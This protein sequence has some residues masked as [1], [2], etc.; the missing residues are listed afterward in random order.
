MANAAGP[1]IVNEAATATNPTLIPNK[2]EVDTGYGW[3]AADTLTAITGGTERMRIDASGDVGIG[4]SAYTGGSADPAAAP[5]TGSSS[6]KILKVDGGLDVD[7][8]IQIVGHS[9]PYGM[10]LWTDVSTGDAYIDNRGDHANYDIH[11]RTRTT[12][13]P[14]DAMTIAGAGYVGIG[15]ATP[16]TY[17]GET[18]ALI[19]G[20]VADASSSLTLSCSTSGSSAI[21]FTD[22][23]STATQGNIVYDHGSNFMVFKT[24]TA[25][26]MRILSDGMLLIGKS[27]SNNNTKGVE[28]TGSTGFVYVGV[29]ENPVIS[30]NRFTSTGTIVQLR[31]GNA[32]KGTISTDG[33]N[34]AFNT[35]SDYR[36]K[37]NIV[38]LTGAVTRVKALQPRRFNWLTTPDKTYDGFIAHEASTVVPEAVTGAKDGTKTLSN[39]IVDADGNVI[40]E[41]ITEAQ[42]ALGKERT[43]VSGTEAEEAVLYIEGDELPEGKNTGDIKTPAIEADNPEYADPAYAADT[44]WHETLTVPEYQGIDQAKLV[45]LLT[46]AIQELIT[47]V[48]TLEAA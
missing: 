17:V 6:A 31:Y 12:G 33:S 30:L 22:V 2:A 47:R 19:I 18:S 32:V 36:L 8:A 39:V 20:K 45:P 23:A 10:D 21:N 41:N 43:L 40:A 9:N 15:N 1:T 37:E 16:S 48:E 35:S 26:R 27:A 42:W 44:V 28:I 5:P 24:N 38:D 46:A 25:E 13:T 11:F 14:V 29:S 4:N 7:A 3:A 34:V